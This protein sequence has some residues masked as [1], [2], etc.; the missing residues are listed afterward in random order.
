MLLIDM[1]QTCG[2]IYTEKQQAGTGKTTLAG[3]R[4]LFLRTETDGFM[5]DGGLSFNNEEVNM[6]A[7]HTR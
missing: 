4:D 7:E 5:T 6:S 3:L 1:S 2:G